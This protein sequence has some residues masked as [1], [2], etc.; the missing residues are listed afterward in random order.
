MKRTDL[1]AVS[2]LLHELAE[3]Y[4]GID[5]TPTQIRSVAQWIDREIARRQRRT[6]E[7]TK[8][9]GWDAVTA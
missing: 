2:G 9:S 5:A 1:E 6:A 7:R 4:E 3:V 8:S